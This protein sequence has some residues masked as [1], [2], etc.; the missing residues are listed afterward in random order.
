MKAMKKTAAISGVAVLAA[1]G[2][3]TAVPA[4]ASAPPM[5]STALPAFDYR[6]CPQLPSGVD[7]AKWRCEVLVADGSMTIGDGAPVGIHLTAVTHAEGPLPDG[8]PGQVFGGFRAAAAEVPGGLLGPWAGFGPRLAMRPVDVGPIDFL[9]QSGAVPLKLQLSGPFLG[10]DCAIGGAGAPVDVALAR[11]PG[12]AGWISQDP[13][14]MKFDAADSTFAVPA[15][16][17]C[18]G[19]D[20]FLDERFGLPSAAGRNQIAVT[21]YYSFKTYNK[22]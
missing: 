10:R 1:A 11:V 22:L 9:S 13:P 3:A 16:Q 5:T 15:T 19:L 14:V 21:A 12:T 18:E 20:R 8:K 7:P 4:S 17:G 2:L 6:D